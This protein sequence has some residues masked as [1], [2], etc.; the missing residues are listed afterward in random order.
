MSLI[1]LIAC[2]NDKKRMNTSEEIKKEL[3]AP[4]DDSVLESAVIYEAN[5]RQYSAEGSFDAFTRDIPKLKQLGV[6]IIWLMPVF[7]ISETKRKATGGKFASLIEDEVERS[8]MLGSYYAVSNF[9]EVNPEFGNK[10]DFRELI[11]TAHENGIYVI[12]DWVPNHTGW[13]HVWIKEHPEFYTKNSDGQI[14]DP[15]KADGTPWG[16]EDVADLNYSNKQL[17][18]EMLREMQ[19]WITEE[20]VDGFRCDMAAE[21]PLV[22]WEWIIP[23]LRE[24]KDIFLLAEAS[25]PELL[26]GEN[27]FD[28]AYAWEGHHLLNDIAGSKKTA[29]DFDNYM[30]RMD[31]LYEKSDILM[32]FLTNHDENSWNG[33]IQ[34]RLGDASATM[35]ALIFTMP[36]MPLIYS[37]QEYDLNHRLKFFEKDS[38]PK[39]KGKVWPLLEK[40]GSL[41][42]RNKALYGAKN[43]ASYNRINTSNDINILA[44]RRDLGGDELIYVANLSNEPIEFT[45]PVSGGFKNAMNGESVN[46]TPDQICIFAPWQYLI[47]TK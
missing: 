34:E 21:V 40:L 24:K 27:L 13:D 4:I 37:G 44:F 35:L 26:N 41:K 15:I 28:M 16:W 42:N 5:I 20:N 1:A 32:N 38:I 14:T 6:K 45:I 33:T 39:Q 10:E 30:N 23:K 8:K 29:A 19:Y 43:A 31:S 36:G 22:F 12:L 18:E 3:I 17:W 9:T 2:E 11:R 25:D 7:P 47:L 46:M